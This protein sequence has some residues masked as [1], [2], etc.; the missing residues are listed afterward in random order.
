MDVPSQESSLTKGRVKQKL[1]TRRALVEAAKDIA[2]EGRSLTIAEVAEVAEVSAAT[3]YRYFSSPDQLIL[4]IAI[5]SAGD[6]V[7]DLPDDPATRLATV[8]DRL[9]DAQF[10]DE[11]VWRALLVASQQRWFA[12]TRDGATRCRCVVGRGSRLPVRRSNHSRARC[13]RRVCGAPRW[14]SCSYTVSTRWLPRSTRAAWNPPKH[15]A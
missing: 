9:C 7:A 13:H 3:A 11:A 5:G 15:E 6:L 12:Q 10:S 4:E 1:R 2:R 14:Q 8:I